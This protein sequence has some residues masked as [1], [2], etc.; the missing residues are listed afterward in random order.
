MN[1][2]PHCPECGAEPCSLHK[3]QTMFEREQRMEATLQEQA[4]LFLNG[5]PML[6]CGGHAKAAH[7]H[8]YGHRVK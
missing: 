3:T 7:R 8:V 4:A 5:G 6:R 1:H 2:F